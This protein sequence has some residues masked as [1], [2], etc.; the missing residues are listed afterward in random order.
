M[1]KNIYILIP[2]YNESEVLKDI[3]N[4]IKREG[5]EKIIVVDDGSTDETYEI[6]KKQKIIVLRH[7]INRGKGAAIKTGFE[8]AKI[9]AADIVVT[10]DGDG[11]HS[12]KDIKKMIKNIDKGYDVVL[13]SRQFKINSMPLVKI[14][15]NYIADLFTW[16]IYGSWVYDSQSGFRAY[17]KKAISLINTKNDRYEYESEV[18]K[19]IS[20][21][22]LKSVNVPIDVFYT[23]YSG[24][25]KNKQSLYNGIGTAFKLM[26]HS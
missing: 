6:A 1:K 23:K 10:I 19:E 5:Y 4:D 14:I 13:G 15:Y 16:I 8:A 7:L 9:L 26:V 22:K 2:V 12:P 21:H 24:L 3:I 25:K 11:Q 17:S 18:I 20:W